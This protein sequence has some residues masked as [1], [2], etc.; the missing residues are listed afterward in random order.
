MRFELRPKLKARLSVAA[1]ND[2]IYSSHVG[3]LGYKISSGFT[4]RLADTL[5]P[6][7]RDA[8]GDLRDQARQELI[9][10]QPA[11]TER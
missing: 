3:R 6:A 7:G 11:A 5:A 10:G 4:L 8:S 1:F 9:L 2:D